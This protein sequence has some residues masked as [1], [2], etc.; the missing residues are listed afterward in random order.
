MIWTLVPVT[1]TSI[2]QL[3][4]TNS[5]EVTDKR[6]NNIYT[7]NVKDFYTIQSQT[8]ICDMLVNFYNNYLKGHT[9]DVFD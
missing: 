7:D 6:I 4:K 3:F 8:A 9:K 5:K 1:W 2:N